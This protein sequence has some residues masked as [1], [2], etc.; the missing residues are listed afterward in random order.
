MV[1][2]APARR[3]LEALTT[4]GPLRA[5]RATLRR[6]ATHHG[7]PMYPLPADA[8]QWAFALILRPV[9]LPVPIRL[10]NQPAGIEPAARLVT[11]AEPLTTL[12]EGPDTQARHTLYAIYL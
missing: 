6:L 8:P 3:W 12:P 11:L 9:D 10:L 2:Y 5:A 4:P 7:Y 1:P